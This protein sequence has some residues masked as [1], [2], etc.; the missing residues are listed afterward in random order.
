MLQRTLDGFGLVVFAAAVALCGCAG[1]SAQPDPYSRSRD[2][3]GP[4]AY[5]PG[6]YGPDAYY[7]GYDYDYEN[8]YVERLERHQEYEREDLNEEQHDEK[9]ALKQQQQQERQ[10]LKSA[11]EWDKQ[12]RREQESERKQQKKVFKQEDRE[13]GDQQQ[14]EWRY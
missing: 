3:Y 9:R 4:G 8:P 10:E 2:P 14:D 1:Q 12:D 13:L 11:G 5:G 7:R 6:A